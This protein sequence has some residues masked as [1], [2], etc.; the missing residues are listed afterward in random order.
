MPTDFDAFFRDYVDSY[1]QA[2]G[3]A[4]DFGRIRAFFADCFVAAGP[5]GVMCGANDERF[6]ETLDQGYQ[7]Y[8]AIRTLR[9]N[10]IRSQITPIDDGHA[11]VKVFYRADYA[12]GSGQDLGISFDVTYILQTGGETPKIF[13]FVAGDEMGLYRKYGLVDEDGAP[14]P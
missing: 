6:A 14:T 5:E 11:M 1:N 9:M 10:F 13:A 12:R 2:L 7:F 4:P 3:P 8:R